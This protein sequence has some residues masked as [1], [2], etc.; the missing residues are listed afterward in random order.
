MCNKLPSNCFYNKKVF[1]FDNCS[2]NF[3]AKAYNRLIFNY[4]RLKPTVT[5]STVNQALAKTLTKYK[6]ELSLIKNP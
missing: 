5:K 6:F 4:R 1:I 3:W 2:L